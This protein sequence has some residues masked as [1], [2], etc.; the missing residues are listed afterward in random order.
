MKAKAKKATYSV[1]S[2]PFTPPATPTD[3]ATITGVAGKIVYVTKVKLSSTQ[4]TAGINVF[5][6]VKR[7]AVNTTGTPDVLTPVPHDSA[8][9]AAGALVK[10][11]TAN[12]GGLGAVVGTLESR[13]VLTPAPASVA[14]GTA[15][16]YLFSA[17]DDD[18]N[19]P[20]AL[21]A[22]EVLAINFGGAAL[23]TGLSVI[24]GFE[25]Y[26]EAV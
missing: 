16:Q 3:M 8:S 2:A 11:Y 24:A 21:R 12:P 10:D 15:Q 20:I 25:F 14:P 9:P 22:N 26:E 7:S 6:L 13:H 5:H 4:T 18:N 17:S 23:P 1:T 19:Q